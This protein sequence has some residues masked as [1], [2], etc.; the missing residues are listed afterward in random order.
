MR[1]GAEFLE[2]RADSIDYAIMEKTQRGV[3]VPLAAGWSDI[4]SWPA[5]HE[6]L[7]K[8]AKG[9][10]VIGDVI[11]DACV[12]SYVLSNGRLVVAIGLKD[13]VVIET[14]DAVLVLGREHGQGVKRV[15][16]A[17]N[18]DRRPET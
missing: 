13:V 2:C 12:N 3:V 1:L 10:V 4:G 15:V 9:N 7:E 5:L 17:L 16:D 11:A 14:S 18:V 8:D 6:F